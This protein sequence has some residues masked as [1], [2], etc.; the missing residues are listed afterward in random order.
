MDFDVISRGGRFF[1]STWTFRPNLW[2]TIMLFV[3]VCAICLLVTLLTLLIC[4]NPFHPIE[5]PVLQ[6][7]QVQDQRG[8]ICF[9]RLDG[10]HTKKL[11]VWTVS[12]EKLMFRLWLVPTKTIKYEL[13][14]YECLDFEWQLM[15]FVTL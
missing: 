11:C 2:T 15:T 14:S 10:W 12:N 1:F 4:E 5:R 13:I 7:S 8:R 9:Q 6:R 3:C